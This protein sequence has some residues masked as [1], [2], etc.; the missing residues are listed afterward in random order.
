MAGLPVRQYS[1]DFPRCFPF[2]QPSQMRY[3]QAE[4]SRRDRLLQWAIESDKGTC[5]MAFS[6]WLLREV[7]MQCDELEAQMIALYTKS[8]EDL[9]MEHYM[10]MA[11]WQAEWDAYQ[12]E[13]VETELTHKTAAELAAAVSARASQQSGAASI[14]ESESQEPVAKR[15]RTVN[16]VADMLQDTQVDGLRYHARRAIE[17]RKQLARTIHESHQVSDVVWESHIQNAEDRRVASL[18]TM[19]HLGLRLE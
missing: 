10:R 18:R 19:S 9:R 16:E 6:V 13:M 1:D 14:A 11:Q 3:R 12:I 17:K 5:V 15:P 7:F 8:E 4:V 2:D